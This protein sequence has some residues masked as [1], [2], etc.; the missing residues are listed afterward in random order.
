[1]LLVYRIRTN[2]R[3]QQQAHGRLLRLNEEI[4]VRNQDIERSLAS[5]KTLQADLARSETKYRGLV[6]RASD[7]ILEVNRL[8]YFTYINPAV[9]RVTGYL[10]H[11]LAETHYTQLIHPDYVLSVKAFLHH[12]VRIKEEFVYLEYPMIS[13][14]G[15]SIWIGQSTHFFYENHRLKNVVVVARD[16]SR[17]KQAEE[18]LVTSRKAYEELV[19]AI[20]IGIYR[21][22]TSAEGDFR[23][24]YVSPRWCQL[25]Q[26]TAETVYND[27]Q[28][29]RRLIHPD[30]EISFQQAEQQSEEKLH[31]VWEGRLQIGDRVRY[32]RIESRG[33]R[34]TNGSIVRHGYQKDITERKLAELDVVRA[35][36]EAE[37][38]SNV[39]TE[40]L[41]N[42]THEMLTPLN[43]IIGFS[44]LLLKSGLSAVQSKYQYAVARSA[45]SL[46]DMVYDV[47]EFSK[48]E[49]GELELRMETIAVV[50]LF[51][52][53]LEL[54]RPLAQSKSIEIQLV[55]EG[56]IPY[57]IRSDEWRLRQV[58]LNLLSNAL[59]FTDR[60]KVE[61]IVSGHSST[62]RVT[63][64]DTGVGIAPELQDRIFDAFVQGDFTT[65]KR[66]GGAGLGL[67]IAQ[68]L[69]V[70]M[71]SELK[72][73]STQGVG[74][75]FYFELPI[76]EAAGA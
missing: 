26:I 20:P 38:A 22:E 50:P 40:F 36:E 31:F 42:M 2:A 52:D 15:S 5:I 32:F 14:S 25:N 18:D 62:V 17:Q 66:F 76:Q 55:F 9:T 56:E 67:T 13:R 74:S 10:K 4:S 72:F 47:L 16:I 30:D 33:Q 73:L 6:E 35:K 59:K 45:Q 11:E 19:E 43:G 23:F 65:T 37:Q 51:T 24:V 63:I 21:T 64:R 1:M 7:I 61:L 27:P 41:A 69:L 53:V 57:S 8:G 75:E 71:G 60:G 54:T 39:K 46:L 12:K 34:L 29:A 44:D 70:K 3:T 68:R 28:T 58:I 49:R 48:M